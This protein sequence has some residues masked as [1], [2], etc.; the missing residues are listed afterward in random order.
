MQVSQACNTLSPVDFCRQLFGE[1]PVDIL[2]A[3]DTAAKTF[4]SIGILI[5]GVRDELSRIESGDDEADSLLSSAAILALRQ[6]AFLNQ[7]SEQLAE[8]MEGG[9]V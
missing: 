3:F 1:H 9:A 8:T 2:N 5:D 7:F 4:A 6:S